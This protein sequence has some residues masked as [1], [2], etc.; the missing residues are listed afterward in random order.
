MTRQLICFNTVNPSAMRKRQCASIPRRPIRGAGFTIAQVGGAL[1]C[2]ANQAAT[3]EA[4]GYGRDCDN[5]HSHSGRARWPRGTSPSSERSVLDANHDGSRDCSPTPST[6]PSDLWRCTTTRANG[7]ACTLHI[8]STSLISRVCCPISV[9]DRPSVCRSDQPDETK[10][11]LPC[12][13]AN[14]TMRS[15]YNVRPVGQAARSG[16]RPATR[17]RP[18]R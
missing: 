17:A 12:T 3:G 10:R 15:R 1:H 7:L 11:L 9:Y 6:T 16:V 2:V 4:S 13:C 5:N 8:S 14:H 18:R